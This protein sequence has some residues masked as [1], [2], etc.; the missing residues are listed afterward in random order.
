MSRTT[1]MCRMAVRDKA[2]WRGVFPSV[3]KGRFHHIMVGEAMGGALLRAG[4]VK[5]FPSAD[6]A[7]PR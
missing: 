4:R 6:G 5:T 1:C 7:L 3:V 2:D